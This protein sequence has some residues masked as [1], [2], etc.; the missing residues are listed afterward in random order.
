MHWQRTLQTVDVHCEG[1][2]GRVITNGVL[3]I[4]GQTMAA[5]LNHINTIDDSLRR[6]LTHEPRGG[7][8]GSVVLLTPPTIPE[9]NAGLI[10]LQAD[11]AHA[12]SGSNAMCAVTALL[13]T[14]M[15]EMKEPETIV[16]LDTAAGSVRAVASCRDGRCKTISL[17]MPPAIVEAI[18][19]ELTTEDWGRIR[20]DICFGGVYYALVDVSQFGISI[21]PSSARTLAE[22]GVLLRDLIRATRPIQHP[23]I[24]EIKGVA[25]VM[26]R[27]NEPDGTMRT[28]TTMWPGRV[29]RSPCGTGSAANL[30]AMYAR[31]IVAPGDVHISRSIIDTEFKLRLL[32]A[33]TTKD[34]VETLAQISGRC[35]IYGLSQIGLDV[36][37]PF[38]GGFLLSDTWGHGIN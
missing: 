16:N 36:C 5:K 3:D 29:D 6:L 21:E 12:M 10:V 1:E 26:F 4:P 35:W 7:P 17:D 19:E 15:V 2:I 34:R 13:E 14:G 20:Y 25:Y 31:G 28:C 30:A 33:K 18:D 23:D 22:T 24:P 11:Q 27:D 38:P 37:D 8:A 9:A 32:S